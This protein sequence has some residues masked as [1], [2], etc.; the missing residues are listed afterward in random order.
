M[1]GGSVLVLVLITRGPTT[2]RRPL[3]LALG[4]GMLVF[5]VWLLAFGTALVFNVG[6][7]AEA[8]R[9]SK[10]WDPEGDFA[11]ALPARV[12]CRLLGGASMFLSLSFVGSILYAFRGTRMIGTVLMVTFGPPLVV[13]VVVL[14]I[15]Y[16][17]RRLT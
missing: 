17:S 1:I 15:L 12:E 9:H 13:I 11:E 8:F 10:H 6:N 4:V 7:R 2:V 3:S 16:W 14:S 5:A